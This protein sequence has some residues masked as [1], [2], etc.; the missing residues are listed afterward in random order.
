MK[1]L[2]LICL[3]PLV[4]PAFA[5]KWAKDYEFVDNPSN[6]LSLV[7]KEGKYGF[8]DQTGRVVVPVEFQEAVEA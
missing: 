8:V 7:K 5:Q 2:L 4:L 6:G 3:L 1:K